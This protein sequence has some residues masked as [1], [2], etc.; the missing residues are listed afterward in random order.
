MT[1]RF[2]FHLL[3]VAA[4]AGTLP[5]GAH[6]HGTAAHVHGQAR[7]AVAVDGGRL[8]LRLEAPNETL[9]GFEHAPR[10]DEERAAVARMRQ[11]LEQAGDLF[12]PTPSAECRSVGVTLDSPLLAGSQAKAGD[13]AEGGHSD[14]E[15]EFVF[16]CAKPDQL[17]DV[18]VRLFEP[19]PRM[20]RL[21]AQ[22][23]GPKVQKAFRLDAKNRRLS[24]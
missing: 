16:E 15:G 20:K 24:W 1:R 3:G 4:L 11:R 9:L 6:A 13:R 19:F 8:S 5:V 22:V 10:N 2:R 23:V 21:D 17:R 14:L 7:L 12:Q 18:E